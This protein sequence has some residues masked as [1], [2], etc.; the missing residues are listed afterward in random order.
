MKSER[1]MLIFINKNKIRNEKKEDYVEWKWEKER[2][3]SKFDERII[4]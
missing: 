4:E 3:V 1:K 2:E